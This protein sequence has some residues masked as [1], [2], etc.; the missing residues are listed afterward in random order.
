MVDSCYLFP[1]AAGT[2]G[3]QGLTGQTAWHTRWLL[4]QGESVAFMNGARGV[5][6]DTVLRPTHTGH[7]P[8]PHMHTPKDTDEEGAG[9]GWSS[10]PPPWGPLG[11][12]ESSRG[13]VHRH[14]AP[15]DRLCGHGGFH[16]LP[17][18]TGGVRW[19]G[20]L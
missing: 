2:S 20:T 1:G 11:E 4:S 7:F 6:P 13:C 10:L 14:R 9:P 12:A 19:L 3:S 15:R 18:A 5:M 17:L 16:L 8:Y